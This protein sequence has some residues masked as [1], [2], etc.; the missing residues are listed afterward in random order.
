MDL[1]RERKGE[2]LGMD[3]AY[4]FGNLRNGGEPIRK[5]AHIVG[6]TEGDEEVTL[7]N[8]VVRGEADGAQVEVGKFRENVRNG[9]EHSLGGTFVSER[10]FGVYTF[11]VD[12]GFKSVGG[13]VGGIPAGRDDVVAVLGFV[14]EGDCAV[15]A[16]YFERVLRRDVAH[17]LIPADGIAVRAAGGLGERFV[18]EKKR[19]FAVELL[20]KVGRRRWCLLWKWERLCFEERHKTSPSERRLG[21][22]TAE[23]VEVDLCKGKTALSQRLQEGGRG[24]EMVKI[25][26]FVDQCSRRLKIFLA[27]ESI[28]NFLALLL[29]FAGGTAEGSRDFSLCLSRCDIVEPFGTDGGRL[30]SEDFDLVATGQMMAHRDKAVIDFGADAMAANHGVDGKRKVKHRGTLG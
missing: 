6:V 27:K 30:G 11:E 10:A 22:F 12:V 15:A 5:S 4:G 17:H 1:V 20:D 3:E 24:A 18:G 25:L 28:E 2:N 14:F 7:E 9:A 21:I 19:L 8:A 23:V 26:E 13:A 29:L 16:V